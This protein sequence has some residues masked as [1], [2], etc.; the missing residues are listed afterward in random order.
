[1]G[2]HHT[3]LEYLKDFIGLIYPELCLCCFEQNPQ[4]SSIFCFDCNIDMPYTDQFIVADN[5]FK[6][7]FYGRIDLRFAASYIYSYKGSNAQ[8]M[9]YALKYQKKNE[10]AIEIGKIMGEK[11]NEHW[12]T[13]ELDMIIPI[14]LHPKKEAWRGYNQSMELAKGLQKTTGIAINTRA[15]KKITHTD[16]QTSKGRAQRLQNVSESFII[17]DISD[18]QGKHILIVDDVVTTGATLEVCALICKKAKAA[19]IS[20][21]TIAMAMS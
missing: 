10:V 9:L 18:I 17:N 16:S 15:V 1:M 6:D 4:K 20:M 5:R 11:I 2:T 12:A 19:S 13:T 3:L 21:A 7:I 14:P 8:K